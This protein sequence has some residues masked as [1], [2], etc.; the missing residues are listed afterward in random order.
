[1]LH[2]NIA[3]TVTTVFNF[4]KAHRG[5]G[6]YVLGNAGGAL[7][8]DIQEY[9][10][11]LWELTGMF[12]PSGVNTK[13]PV[14]F[15]KMNLNNNQDNAATAVVWKAAITG[16]D[17]TDNVTS[18]DHERLITGSTPAYT[19]VKVGLDSNEDIL[20][21]AST[22]PGAR[23]YLAGV[24]AKFILNTPTERSTKF[25]IQLVQFHEEMVPGAVSTA[26]QT[27]FW[28]AMIKRESFS[29]LADGLN[30]RLSK[31]MKVLRS[32]TISMDAPEAT[33]DHLLS[34]T[35][36]LSLYFNMNRMLNFNWGINADKQKMEEKDVIVDTAANR[37]STH[38]HPKAR[39]YLMIKAECEKFPTLSQTVHPSYDMVMKFYHKS[40]KD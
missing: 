31:Y 30:S 7:P 40:I 23:G 29:P 4:D 20:N 3:N 25:I 39:V 22:G 17:P 11:H 38:V 32:E 36:T 5:F 16:V 37:F 35:K 8:T 18:L 15:Y 2:S 28:Q 9:P 14:I 13:Y 27:Q 19:M 24:S 6:S 21:N 34:R 10:L 33:E 26:N 1:L 12:Q